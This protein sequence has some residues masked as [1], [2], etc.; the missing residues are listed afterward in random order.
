MYLRSAVNR[1]LEYEAGAEDTTQKA[2]D[3]LL[4]QRL[5]EKTLRFY[6]TF[7]TFFLSL[8][9]R[10]SRSHLSTR[11]PGSEVSCRRMTSC[12]PCFV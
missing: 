1:L 11:P 7:K 8:T 5:P 4:A 12:Y 9:P 6:A 2:R 10:N 3:D